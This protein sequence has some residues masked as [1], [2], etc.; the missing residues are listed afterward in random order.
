LSRYLLSV[1]DER[2]VVGLCHIIFGAKC[3]PF[4]VRS[5]ELTAGQSQQPGRVG[6][7]ESHLLIL[8]L[9]KSLTISKFRVCVSL[10]ALYKDGKIGKQWPRWTT[11]RCQGQRLVSDGDVIIATRSGQIRPGRASTE[12]R[13]LVLFACPDNSHK[14]DR[15]QQLLHF[16]AAIAASIVANLPK[17]ILIL[18]FLVVLLLLV[19]AVSLCQ[20]GQGKGGGTTVCPNLPSFARLDLADHHNFVASALM[21]SL[22]RCWIF[23]LF[24]IQLQ[25]NVYSKR[26]LLLDTTQLSYLKWKTYSSSTSSQEGWSEESFA[27]VK[28]GNN[29]R[30][31]TVCDFYKDTADHWLRTPYIARGN[32]RR[33]F[34]EMTFTMR[35]CKEFPQTALTCKETFTLLYQEADHDVANESASLPWNERS[36]RIV[37]KITSNGARYAHSAAEEEEEETA[38]AMA[39]PLLAEHASKTTVVRSVPVSKNGVYFAFQDEGS[40]TSL[41]SIKVYYQV[42][43]EVLANFA[44]FDETPAGPELTSIQETVGQCVDN[45][46]PTGESMPKFVCKADGS[47]DLLSGSCQC[48]AGFEAFDSHCSACK[49][50]QFKDVKGSAACRPCPLH[51]RTVSNGSV[52]CQCEPG[53]YRAQV[54]ALSDPCTQPPSKPQNARVEFVDQNS[55]VIAWNRPVSNGGRSELWY[56]VDCRDCPAGIR[57]GS[58]LLASNRIHVTNVTISGLE[59]STLYTVFVYAENDVSALLNGL[60]MYAVVEVTTTAL[61]PV[62]LSELRVE[63]VAENEVS[64]AWHAPE[65]PLHLGTAYEPSPTLQRNRHGKPKL[66]VQYYLVDYAA[67]RSVATSRTG[68]HTRITTQQPHAFVQG[69]LADTEYGFK[70]RA[71]TS[72]GWSAWTD[73]KWIRTSAS[74]QYNNVA[75][76]FNPH[77]SSSTKYLYAAIGVLL[78]IISVLLTLAY[79]RRLP[80]HLCGYNKQPSDLDVLEYKADQFSSDYNTIDIYNH[81]FNS[82]IVQLPRRSGSSF[83]PYVDPLAYEDPKQAL[84]EFANEIDSTTVALDEI[85]GEGEFGEV[86]KGK[87]CVPGSGVE[88]VAIKSLKTGLS[89]KAKLDFLSEASIMGQFDHPNVIRLK[90]VISRSEPAMIV[91]E[92]LE[93][94]SLDNFL[95]RNGD[96]LDTVQLVRMLNDVASGMAYLSDKGYTHRDLAARNILVDGKLC[97]KIADFGLSRVL[98]GSTELAY[99]T[100]GGKIPVRW[101]AP[102][103]ITFRKFTSSSDVWSFGIVVWEVLSLGDRPYWDWTN[104]EVVD[105]V[106]QGYR[107]PAPHNCPA[108]LYRLMLTCWDKDYT[109]RP[110]FHQLRCMLSDFLHCPD[111]MYSPTFLTGTSQQNQQFHTLSARVYAA[112]SFPYACSVEDFCRKLNLDRR[113]AQVFHAHGVHRPVIVSELTSADLASMGLSRVDQEIVMRALVKYRLANSNRLQQSNAGTVGRRSSSVRIYE[114]SPVITSSSRVYTTPGLVE[115]TAMDNNDSLPRR[116]NGFFV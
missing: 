9:V 47:W 78:F 50:G 1:N 99:T 39:T 6:G 16:L 41:L 17:L 63:S 107:L 81:K 106:D 66:H 49:M 25:S 13:S 22:T 95:K 115:Q 30:T 58:E 103:A 36:Y 89:V 23:L 43:E 35:A 11:A 67:R 93:N 52:F 51:S 85:I 84:R 88:V 61:A 29:W 31:Y 62:I 3:R 102:E 109:C 10:A 59:P 65:V 113:F 64:L 75:G 79:R 100:K 2:G 98:E 7:R 8:F 101:T 40:C 32:A 94:G 73:T 83:K 18:C 69:L 26:V 28:E 45:A 42:C 70:V 34:I 20:S 108:T 87:M 46:K 112:G 5:V 21:F 27:N 55:V 105:A 114:K 14:K 12:L 71:Y 60:P 97:C 44:W 72:R 53:Y 19:F 86:Y 68:D 111:L 91:T 92:Y 110:T 74:S 38:A 15:T 37:D 24:T 77:G 56:R 57:Y 54:D 90:G 82:A 96:R 104:Q 80:F 33:L 116:S 4:Y 76:G 48:N